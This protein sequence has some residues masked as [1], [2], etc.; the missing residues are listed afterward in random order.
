MSA[1]SNCLQKTLSG[2]LNSHQDQRPHPSYLHSRTVD[3]ISHITL[4]HHL[5][6]P[7]ESARFK[8]PSSVSRL[9][10]PNTVLTSKIHSGTQMFIPPLPF[11]SRTPS[12]APPTTLPSW[13][14]LPIQPSV[15]SSRPD[16]ASS[17]LTWRTKLAKRY[18]MQEQNVIIGVVV[19]V[20]VTAF[21]VGCFYFCH[22]YGSSIRVRRRSRSR[23]R[24]GSRY[25]SKG[26]HMSF[27]ASSGESA[28]PPPPP[29]PPPP[30]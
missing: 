20:L 7:Q 26:S 23:R 14:H 4:S 9:R 13:L 5:N 15:S 19:G 3:I 17:P 8:A 1:N 12:P 25:G 6:P 30:G 27:S 18:S 29:P 16:D 11:P 22:R 2:D 24:H 10:R 28:P 21:L